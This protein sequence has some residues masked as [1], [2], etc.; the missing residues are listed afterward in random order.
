MPYSGRRFIEWPLQP[1]T[2]EYE[3]CDLKPVPGSHF[4]VVHIPTKREY[5]FDEEYTYLRRQKKSGWV[6]FVLAVGSE[7]IKIGKSTNIRA[8]LAGMK[9]DC[10]HEL[11]PLVVMPCGDPDEMEKMLHW[12]LDEDRVRGEWFDFSD[13]VIAMMELA[14]D[15]GENAVVS[16][17]LEQLNGIDKRESTSENISHTR[18]S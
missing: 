1:A 15:K 18:D 11:L 13:Q 8:R 7:R 9:T 14:R 3:D 16:K 12:S 6:Y 5:R 4:C 2:C 17:I 10:P